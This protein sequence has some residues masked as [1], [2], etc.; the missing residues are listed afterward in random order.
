MCYGPARNPLR[1]TRTFPKPSVSRPSV[2]GP[3]VPGHRLNSQFPDRLFPNCSFPK[4]AI[5]RPSVSGPPVHG[6][7]LD[8]QFHDRSFQ[9]DI[10]KP[11]Q[12][13]RSPLHQDL[14]KAGLTQNDHT[15]SDNAES[16]QT[17]ASQHRFIQPDRLASTRPVGTRSDF[18]AS[19]RSV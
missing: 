5:S 11:T 8:S 14:T 4:P 19:Y 9:A 10:A 17:Q 13:R 12:M 7:L 6:H 1:V 18:A 15:P 2:P 3:F 16:D